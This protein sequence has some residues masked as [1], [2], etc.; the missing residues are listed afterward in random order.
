[1]AA[2]TTVRVTGQVER[3]REGE[4]TAKSESGVGLTA[5]LS[6]RPQ[7]GGHLTSGEASESRELLREVR[8]GSER[9]SLK[10]L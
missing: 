9:V 8:Q 6:A 1:M 2:I 7:L 5:S 10:F 3:S 4:A